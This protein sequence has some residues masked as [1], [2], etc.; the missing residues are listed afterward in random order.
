MPSSKRARRMAALARRRPAPDALA[1]RSARAR[2]ARA[3]L[4]LRWFRRAG[5]DAL[6]LPGGGLGRLRARRERAHPRA[7]RRGEDVRR[8]YRPA[9]GRG[10][11]R[12][13]RACRSSTSRRCARCPAT[14]SWRCTRRWPRWTRTSTWRAARAT[15]PPP[16]ASASASGCPRCSSPR[17]S[18]SPCCSPTSA[19][20]SS[21]P[22]LRCRHRG[23]VARAARHQ[24]R[25][26]GG[27]G[28][29]PPAPLRP[30]RAHLGAVRHA[31]QPGRGRARR[32]GH[33]APRPRSCAPDL[34][35]PVRRGDAAAGQ[36]GRLPLGRA[37]WA[38]PCWRKVADWLDPAQLHPALHQHALPGR[39]LVRG[40][41]L[42][43]PRV[44]GRA[45]PAPRLH[46]PRGARARG[47]RPE[48]RQRAPRRVHLL[49]GP[50]RGLRPGG[51]RGADGQPQG[52]RAARSS[53]RAAARHRPGAT[54]RL[55]FVPTHALEL[56]EMAAARE[57]LA[58][59]EVEPRTPLRKP[60]DVLAQHLVTCALGGGFTREALRAEVRDA[61]RATGPHRR[62]VR[63]DARAGAR[64]RPHA[65]RLPGVPPRGGARGPLRRGGRAHRAAAPAQHRHH[66][67][68]RHRA[69]A[70]LERRAASAPSRSPTSAACA[71]GHLPLRGQAAGVLPLQGHDGLRE[72]REGARPRRRRA[73]AAAACPSP[74]RSPPR[75]AARCTPRARA[76]STPDELAAAW[77]VLDAQARLSRI[78][79]D[80]HAASRRRAS[81]R[82]GHHLFL[83]P[84]EGRLVHEGLAALL[85][86]RLTRLQKATFSLSVND[87]GM[88]LLTPD[89]L[90]LRGGAA[91]RPLHPRAAGG[92]HPG[93]RQPERAGAAAVPRHR[94]RGGAGAAGAARRAQVH[95]P[96][97]GQRR[98]CSTTSSL[99]YDPDNLL[100][101]QARRE[102]LEQQFEQ[103]R[104]APHPGAPG[105][106]PRGARPRPRGPR[107][108]PSRSSSSA[109]ARAS[110]TSP[111]W[112]AWSA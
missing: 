3:A 60:L 70:L 44:G 19:P 38:S 92:G 28:P 41:A 105:A 42:R 6:S 110:P 24:A 91:P 95:A 97:A 77:P 10:R 65:A 1:R 69:A 76:T 108:W 78:P 27:A 67:L 75:C 56:V 84:F 73:G 90:P 40:P 111:C 53:A 25:H 51:A 88:E 5:L 49:A 2:A 33:P 86:L 23:R 81:T 9:R 15:P 68:G 11:A 63:V 21:S 74:A 46:R 62:G 48:G 20:R 112:S 61:P 98:R 57:A 43:P 4:P 52:H 107:R 103:G 50:G 64:G 35:R 79:A 37:T 101:L 99:K 12:P 14:S 72:A 31:R 34:E 16:C 66:H 26:P 106:Q 45:R 59:G 87:Y 89:A 55:L 54:C 18:R 93:E 47:A 30:G 100:L 85:A 32:R 7:H 94:A 80:G 39:A 96:G 83:Y 102:V 71:R 82:E 109:S 58:R 29:R 104:L 17:P 8:L 22:R 36:R 13:A